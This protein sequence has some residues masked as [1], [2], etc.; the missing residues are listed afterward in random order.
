[1]FTIERDTKINIAIADKKHRDLIY[2]IRHQVY[3]IE[4]RQHSTNLTGAL[5]DSLDQ[6]N[7]YLVAT[8]GDEI[9]GFVSI[10]PPNQLYSVDK[11]FA[12]ESFPFSFD[13]G[14]FEVRL[15]TVLKPF[16]NTNVAA[17]LMYSAFRWIESRKGTRVVAIGREE[18]LS[19]YTKVGLESLGLRTKSGE[20]WYQA[21]TAPI[22]SL[23][24]KARS[25][26]FLLSKLKEQINW[27]LDVPFDRPFT[28]YHGG[29]F[30]KS[31]GEEFESLEKSRDIINA[32][33]LDAWFAPSPKVIE[34]LTEYLPWLVRTSPP[35]NCEGLVGKISQ[36]RGI[37]E[38][39]LL[40]GAGSSALIYLTFREFLNRS[41]R[42][43]IL[44]PTYGEY[45]H[46]LEQIIRC[47]VDRF[48][49][50]KEAGF[51]VIAEA[52]EEKIQNN[53]DLVIL[54]NPNNPT[55]QYLDRD[56]LQDMLHRAPK[57]TLFWIDETYIDYI[58]KNNSLEEFAWKNENIIICKSMSKVYALSGMRVAY[59]CG[60]K[61]LLE[62]LKILTPPW[63]IGL[64]SQVAATTA[65]KDAA[66][67]EDRYR[68]THL[69]RKNLAHDLTALCGIKTFSGTANFILC[70]LDKNIE[71]ND[72]LEQCKNH[73]LFIRDVASMG[74]SLEKNMI[75]IA[76]KD[77]KTN[78]RMIDIL[79]K[80]T[81]RA[82]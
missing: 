15:L 67:Y 51:K 17:L 30:F 52:L 50:H 60:S 12:R 68:E 8:F 39:N 72:V 57:K 46:V 47:R 24:R 73:G 66:Y 69:L 59:L 56:V 29:A 20:V 18:I 74:Y 48:V 43:L 79:Q 21:M 10:T 54:V 63:V 5:S 77:E 38:D 58:G 4:L 76:V 14:L 37:P 35:T 9:L 49:L 28:C 3:G 25:K 23:K 31:I 45:A 53:Y 32:D 33:V 65:L 1:M 13:D 61:T 36:V 42:V 70:E 82:I 44:D 26:T 16:R 22:E 34:A 55:G 41:S 40:V 7:I 11:Y 78:K 2:K 71:K 80:I 27:K 75:R 64:P 6:F 81:R 62:K 19:V